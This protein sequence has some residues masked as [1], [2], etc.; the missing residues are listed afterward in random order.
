M[1]LLEE[2]IFINPAPLQLFLGQENLSGGH[3]IAT[4]LSGPVQTKITR[5]RCQEPESG[6]TDQTPGSAEALAIQSHAWLGKTV[7][8]YSREEVE[9]A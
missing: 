5:E 9:G 3:F 2:E 4:Y 8:G 6:A 7:S 1:L